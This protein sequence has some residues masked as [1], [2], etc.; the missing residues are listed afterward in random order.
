LP[1]KLKHLFNEEV[2]RSIVAD[3]APHH[4]QFD[5][6]SFVADCMNGLE[7]LELTP[8][9]MQIAKAMHRALPDDFSTASR[10][11]EASLG[12]ELGDG[13]GW[14]ME[15]LRYFPHMYFVACYGIGDFEASMRFPYELTK[16]STAEGSIRAFLE[17]YPERTY[18]RLVEWTSDTNMHVRRLVSEG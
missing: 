3:L 9:A 12:P 1:A 4:S 6:A 15:P 14:G 10:I 11:V 5:T 8:R 7:D 18:E 2:V 16:R 17:A 13:D